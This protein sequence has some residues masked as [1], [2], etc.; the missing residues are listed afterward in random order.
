V[1]VVVAAAEVAAGLTDVSVAVI[2][3]VI[4]CG[5]VGAVKFTVKITEHPVAVHVVAP[6]LTP[7][8]VK[9]V[10][11]TVRPKFALTLVLVTVTGIDTAVPTVTV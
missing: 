4:T 6:L 3:K 1:T 2:V 9:V 8:P 7:K 10:G 5:V 11:D